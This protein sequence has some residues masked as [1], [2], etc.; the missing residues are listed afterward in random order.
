MQFLHPLFLVAAATILIPVIIHLF[1]FRRYKK[2][3]FTNVSFLKELKEE[4]AVRS[5]LRNL[6]VLLL[7]CLAIIALVLAFAQPFVKKNNGASSDEPKHVMIYLDNSLSMTALKDEVPLLELA[8]SNARSVVQAYRKDDVFSVISN[9]LDFRSRNI[10][11]QK[12]ALAMIEDIDIQPNTLML[13]DLLSFQAELL[14]EQQIRREAVSYIFSDFQEEMCSGELMV[15][16]SYQ[17]YL[18]PLRSTTQQ[19]VGIDS[20]WLEQPVVVKNQS[21]KLFVAIHNYGDNAIENTRFSYS[22][23]RINKPLGQI[24][25]AANSVRI[26]TV[27]LTFNESGYQVLA[28]QISDYPVQFDDTFFV[29]FPVRDMLKVLELHDQKANTLAKGFKWSSQLQVDAKTINQLDY[30]QLSTYD[31]II[32]H[33]MDEWSTGLQASLNTYLESGGNI[34]IIPTA[35]TLSSSANSF[36]RQKGL[37]LSNWS[38]LEQEVGSINTS[39]FIFKDVFENPK[40]NLYLPATKG[41]YSI[42]GSATKESILTYR[43]GTAFLVGVNDNNGSLY[44]TSAPLDASYN[45]LIENPAILV[46]MIYKMASSSMQ[47]ESL[48]YFIGTDDQVILDINSEN[49]DNSDGVYTYEAGQ[50]AFIPAQQL[51]QGKLNLNTYGQVETAQIL[52]LKA[53]NTEVVAKSAFNYDRKESNLAYITMERLMEE[54]GGSIEIINEQSGENLTSLVE[55]KEQGL[56]LWTLFLLLALLFLLSESLILRFWKVN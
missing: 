37:G 29:S 7:R 12:E 3:F 18:M 23:D 31:L 43:N 26:D 46:P 11:D 41:Q 8:K 16:S 19:N 36:L 35:E 45:N 24:D 49:S 51:I 42:S 21:T 5:R 15:D 10:Y 28:F 39:S 44:L 25:I 2:V 33:E 54:L 53:P 50:V 47:A 34:W 56:R 40:D 22:L 32:M 1:Y 48:A 6:L 38:T 4:T 27:N 17:A 52:D 55:E 13:E 9:Q 20:V 14:S 30:G